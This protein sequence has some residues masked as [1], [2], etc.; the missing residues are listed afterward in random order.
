MKDLIP[1]FNKLKSRCTTLRGGKY[2]LPPDRKDN[3]WGIQ[4]GDGVN[5]LTDRAA[6]KLI[7]K[8]EID[9]GIDK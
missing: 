7:K 6:E 5:P 3:R 4:E 9:Q 8:M 2:L 1:R